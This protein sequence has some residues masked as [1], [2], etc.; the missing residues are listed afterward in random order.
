MERVVFECAQFLAGRGHEVGV[1]AA[2]ADPIPGV[3]VHAVSVRGRPGFLRGKR[4]FDAASRILPT[5][6]QDV[7]NTHGVVCPF[8]GVHWVQSLHAAWLD[9]AKTMRHPLSAA[10]FKQ[11]LNPVH[12][13]LLRLEKQHFAE[14]RYRKLIATTPQVVADLGRY[15]NVPAEDVAIVPNGFNP[16]EF[17]PA[18]RAQRRDEFRRSLNLAPDH[19]ALLFV[20]NELQRKGYFVLLD[21]LRQLGNK[22][23]RLLVIGRPAQA[24]VLRAAESRGIG[25]Q[26]LALGPSSDV[27]AMHAAADLFVL[28][29]QYEAFSLAILESLGSGLP[30]LTTAVPGAGD[31]IQPGVNGALQQNP[32]DPAEL[33][34]LLKPLLDHGR[35]A[36][37]SATTAATVGQYQ[38]PVVLGKYEE[39]L[40]SHSVAA[41]AV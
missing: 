34:A 22:N 28:P 7:L 16:A 41:A 12:P 37:L 24:D 30:V 36:R 1:L 23:V 32:L 8:G 15:Y 40:A 39:I 29:T 27:A 11:R 18:R 33:A 20:A 2:E 35:L 26:V 25:G 4:Y 17:N 6:P 21:A 10:R 9:R 5:I 38:W 14:R 3:T 13:I 31:A 19:I